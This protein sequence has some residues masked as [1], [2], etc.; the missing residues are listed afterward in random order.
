MQQV[1]QSPFLSPAC[2][3][4]RFAPL[5]PSHHSPRTIMF[6]ELN[7]NSSS[8]VKVVAVRYGGVEGSDPN[9]VVHAV[10]RWIVIRLVVVVVVFQ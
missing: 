7:G 4:N 6:W 3:M 9:L 8:A 5:S 2:R 1:R 10:V